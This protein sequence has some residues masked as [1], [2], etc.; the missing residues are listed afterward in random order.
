V[1]SYSSMRAR[2]ALL[3]D[4][5][6]HGAY[7]REAMDRPRGRSWT[8]D[9]VRRSVEGELDGISL[10]VCGIQHLIAMERAAGRPRD[11]DDLQR[12]GD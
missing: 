7:D 10:R 2:A 9:E 4:G 12:L 11:L 5:A 8:E 1:T 6:E 3:G